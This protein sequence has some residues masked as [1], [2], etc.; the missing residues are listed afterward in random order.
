MSHFKRMSREKN[1]P[2]PAMTLQ[3]AFACA[4]QRIMDA[5]CPWSIC[6]QY[7]EW[8][9]RHGHRS[10]GEEDFNVAIVG[11]HGQTPDQLF[12]FKHA[13]LDGA[14]QKALDAWT[15]YQA[16]QVQKLDKELQEVKS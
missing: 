7:T 9:H 12:Q 8:V 1:K 6:I 13:T 5:G 3:E 2:P 10:T 16:E 14:I 11:D 15:C 4:R